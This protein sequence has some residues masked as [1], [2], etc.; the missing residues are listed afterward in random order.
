MA[1][2]SRSDRRSNTMLA[3]LVTS[4]KKGRNEERERGRQRHTHTQADPY[5]GNGGRLKSPALTNLFVG[6]CS[7]NRAGRRR[8]VNKTPRRRWKAIISGLAANPVE[9]VYPRRSWKNRWSITAVT[10]APPRPGT[11]IIPAP[12]LHRHIPASILTVPD[13]LG[14]IPREREKSRGTRG[15]EKE[16]EEIPSPLVRALGRNFSYV[17]IAS[18]EIIMQRHRLQGD[19]LLAIRDQESSRRWSL[20]WWIIITRNTPV[21]VIKFR[22]KFLTRFNGQYIFIRFYAFS[23]TEYNAQNVKTNNQDHQ[24]ELILEKVREP[25]VS[26][27]YRNFFLYLSSVSRAR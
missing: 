8:P 25:W 13:L 19:C 6:S 14:R 27:Y 26:F 10:I 9:T 16:V 23:Y 11:P 21:T 15:V 4:T 17:R 1:A 24:E 22:V 7:A 20:Y 3:G 2:P 12:R 5:N 18:L